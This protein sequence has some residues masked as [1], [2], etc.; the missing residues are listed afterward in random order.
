[1][2]TFVAVPVFRAKDEILL[3][4]PTNVSHPSGVFAGATAAPKRAGRTCRKSG[5]S[6]LWRHSVA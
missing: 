2:L 5:R 4:R 3:A 1:L 6:I